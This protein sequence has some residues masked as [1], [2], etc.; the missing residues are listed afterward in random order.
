MGMHSNGPL[1]INN[2]RIRVEFTDNEG[3]QVLCDFTGNGKHLFTDAQVKTPIGW[4]RYR[5]IERQ[6]DSLNY[7]KKDIL[8]VINPLLNQEGQYKEIQIT[9]EE[10]NETR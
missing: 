5:R 9:K 2:H 10:T 8:S 4:E 7:C 3:N 6:Y 1:D